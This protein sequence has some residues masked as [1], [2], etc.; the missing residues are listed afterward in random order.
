M[1]I[2]P[3]MTKVMTEA[4]EITDTGLMIEIDED[5]LHSG[6]NL[7]ATKTMQGA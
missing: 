3:V 2:V 5:T 7:E 6:Q 1:E 4:E